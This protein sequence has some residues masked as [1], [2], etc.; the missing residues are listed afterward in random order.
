MTS[1]VFARLFRPFRACSIEKVASP[2]PGRWPGRE[3]T[4]LWGLPMGLRARR[5]V[6]TAI[7]KTRRTLK[8]ISSL[9]A[10]SALF[11]FCFL[12][13]QLS[14]ATASALHARG[15]TVLPNPQRVTLSDK[16][17]ELT[18]AWRLVFGPAVESAW[19]QTPEAKEAMTKL[20]VAVIRFR[21]GLPVD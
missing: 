11:T 8:H 17:L 4:P 6:N 10:S 5:N 19:S 1:G 21:P 2:D 15:Y 18:S 12:P 14:A 7:M 20:P 16:D 13:A 3:R 9:F